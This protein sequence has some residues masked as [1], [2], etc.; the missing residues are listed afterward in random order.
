MM[1]ASARR[2]W[3]AC[4]ISREQ[5]LSFA[6]DRQ[7]YLLQVTPYRDRYGL[8]WLIVV[9]VPEADFMAQI[10]RNTR[11]AIK[12]CIL[13][14]AIASLVGILTARWIARPILRVNQAA[15]AIADG[16]LDQTVRCGS[17]RELRDLAS[18]FNS[19]AQ[20]LRKSF[21]A[22]AANNADLEQARAE[23][24]AANEQLEEK[25]EERTAELVQANAEIAALNERLQAE[26]LRMSAE[27]GIAKKITGRGFAPRSRVAAY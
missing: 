25:V 9:V 21:A 15:S 20:Q 27:L 26:N 18:S 3:K 23:L 6:V 2:C 1:S 4:L 7:R 14:L 22:L 12:L 24:A 11:R 8:D 5:Q 17:I 10:H 16:Q 19:M 13:A